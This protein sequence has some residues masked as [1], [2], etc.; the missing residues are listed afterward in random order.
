MRA[1]DVLLTGW[2]LDGNEVRI[3]ASGLPARLFQHE[4]DHLD[5]T[6][7]LEHLQ[8]LQ[9]KAGLRILR[10]RQLSDGSPARSDS[11]TIDTAGNAVDR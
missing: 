6:L 10:E 4:I 8:P 11:V 1:R 2:D 9:R 5:G 7:L 3:E